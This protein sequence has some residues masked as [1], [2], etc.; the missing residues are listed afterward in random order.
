MKLDPF[1]DTLICSEAKPLDKRLFMF[2][3]EKD[4]CLSGLLEQKHLSHR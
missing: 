4:N 3:N 2:A 1:S